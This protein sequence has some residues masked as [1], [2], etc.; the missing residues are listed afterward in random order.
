MRKMAGTSHLHT[1]PETHLKHRRDKSS[2]GTLFLLPSGATPMITSRIWCSSIGLNRD[3]AQ[4]SSSIR[5]NW[6]VGWSFRF[7]ARLTSFIFSFRRAEA[8]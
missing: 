7:G 3:M 4:G 8:R 2:E 1:R 6:F 5:M